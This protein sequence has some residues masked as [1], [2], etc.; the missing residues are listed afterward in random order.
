MPGPLEAAGVA[1]EPTEYAPLAMDRYI[2]GLWTQRSELRDASVAYLAS[3]FYSASRF[4]SLI[5]GLNR[6]ITSKLTCKRRPGLS[7]YNA[8]TFPRIRSFYSFKFMQDGVQQLHVMADTAS[9]I[10]DATPPYAAPIFTKSAGAGPARFLGVLTSL[11]FTDGVETKKWVHSAKT[12]QANTQYYGGDSVTDSYDQT[13]VVLTGPQSINITQIQITVTAPHPTAP[14]PIAQI[15]LTL[16]HPLVSENAVY[17]TLNGLTTVPALNG[18]TFPT[19]GISGNTVILQQT[20][21]SLSPVGPTAETGTIQYPATASTGGVSG[22]A[23]P[24]WNTT[25]GGTTTDGTIT[26]QNFGPAVYDMTPPIPTVAPTATP[27]DGTLYWQPNT[28][29]GFDQC[30]IDPNGNYQVTFNWTGSGPVSGTGIPQW[31]ATLNSNTPDGTILWL[32]VGP[33]YIWTPNWKTPGQLICILDSNGN[34]QVQISGSGGTTSGTEPTWNTVNGGTTTD[35]TGSGAITWKNY[36]P[37]VPLAYGPYKYAYSYVSVDG[38]VSTASPIFS[39]VTGVVGSEQGLDIV[40]SGP[41]VAD[42]QIKEIWIWRTPQNGATL[43]YAGKTPNPNP[44]QISTWT[45][46]DTVPDQSATGGPQL[47]PLIAAPIAGSSAAGDPPSKTATA[48]EYHLQRVWMIDGSQVIWSGGPDTIVGNGNTAFPPQNVMQ[49]PEQLTRLLSSVTNSAALIV[50]GTANMYA[51][52]GTGTAA[53]PFYPVSYM[54]TVGFLN[55]DAITRVASTI[56]G[57]SNNGKGVELDPGS[58]YVEYGF[59]IGDQFTNM[60][61]GGQSGALFDPAST[62]VTWYEKQSADSALYVADGNIGWFRY[63]PVAAPEQGFIWSPYAAITGGTSAV[64]SVEVATGKMAL[65][66]GPSGTGPILMRDPSTWADNGQ[67]FPSYITL[68]NVVLCQSGEVAEVAHVCLDA[69]RQGDRPQVGM[70]YDEIAETPNIGFDMLDWTS[71]DP[72][73]LAESETLYSDRYVTSQD[74]ECPKCR[75]VQIK[76]EWPAQDAP[77]E[78]MGHAIFGAKFA[79][80]RQQPG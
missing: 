16:Q 52:L 64:Q 73:T 45:W 53:D 54:P 56:F 2:T 40:L 30:L 32:N 33:A 37:G 27:K 29:F 72:P 66:I 15:T 20:N 8:S 14:Y 24:A 22:G 76:I 19:A 21:S 11:Y 25:L 17:V 55:Y 48:P 65:L 13:Q 5:D 26:W 38:S 7:V 74:G 23:V 67:V 6:E 47:N 70:L 49:F 42:P 68:G 69:Y 36:G 51:I 44:G 43:V 31:A 79:E 4:D 57:F 62:Y 10:Y 12:W 80:R 18:E 39:T 78:L 28:N 77:D 58:G 35:G 34:L 60:T 75:H 71:V 41:T 61:T 3:K 46:T 63:S 9:T 59:P 50:F 1:H